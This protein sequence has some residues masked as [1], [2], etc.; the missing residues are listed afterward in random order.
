MK[1][2]C[3]LITLAVAGG[4]GFLLNI[5]RLTVIRARV[6]KGQALSSAH[7]LPCHSDSLSWRAAFPKG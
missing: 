4:V 5:S 7:P 3:E 1:E 6:L 2:T